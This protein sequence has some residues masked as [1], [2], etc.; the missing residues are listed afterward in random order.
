MGTDSWRSLDKRDFKMLKEP[1]TFKN[2]KNNDS[3]ESRFTSEEVIAILRPLTS[4]N[5]AQSLVKQ[6]DERGLSSSQWYWAHKIAHENNRS[7][8]P[9][10][11]AFKLD[12]D[13]VQWMK[14]ADVP[15]LM[16]KF[17]DKGKVKL[18]VKGDYI[19]VYSGGGDWLNRVGR[20][21]GDTLSPK[22]GCSPWIIAQIMLLAKLKMDFMQA[23]GKQWGR[24]FVCGREL[25][26]EE[27]VALGIGPICR[28]KF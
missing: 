3:L 5:F 16:W 18:F 25:E 19:I 28:A 4:N 8:S 11:T 23:Y 1:M 9:A 2:P 13:L 22:K 14:D 15:R 6:F 20:I 7:P 17:E 26:N 24:C 10:A 21:D 27:S 12:C